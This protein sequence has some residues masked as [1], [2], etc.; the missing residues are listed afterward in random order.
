[1]KPLVSKLAPRPKPLSVVATQPSISRRVSA[2]YLTAQSINTCH[3]TA[4]QS[5]SIMSV[6]AP[7]PSIIMTPAMISGRPVT[8]WM[9]PS[10]SAAAALLLQA[11]SY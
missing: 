11:S 7:P 4:N 1:M 8:F 10:P 2:Q 6:P 9:K 3:H 5:K